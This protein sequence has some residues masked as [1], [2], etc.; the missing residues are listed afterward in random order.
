[1]EESVDGYVAGRRCEDSVR[2]MVGRMRAAGAGQG[3]ESIS[4]QASDIWWDAFERRGGMRGNGCLDAALITNKCRTPTKG[5]Q[6]PLHLTSHCCSL[7]AIK[8][9]S[10]HYPSL[11]LP[12]LCSIPLLPLTAP[13]THAQS[14]WEAC[15]TVPAPSRTQQGPVNIHPHNHRFTHV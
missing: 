13:E 10:P 3:T 15:D 14:R 2:H 11:P 5:I 12:P 7:L 1:M 6:M 4:P 9:S 8:A